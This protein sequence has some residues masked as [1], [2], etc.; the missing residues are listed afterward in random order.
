VRGLV[1]PVLGTDAFA[2]RGIFFDKIEGA[3]WKVPP[4][5][6]V[7][8]AVRERHDVDGFRAWS[9]KEGLMHVQPPA[10]VLERMATVRLHLDACG[11]DNGPLRVVA[12][13]HTQG[14]IS[15]DQV[16]RLA[17][18]GERVC[19]V[20]RGGAVIMRPLL[21]HSSSPSE[22]P[23]HRRVIHLEFACCE[24][25]APLEWHRKVR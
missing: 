7:T 10:T 8:I 3:N 1:D 22:N 13:S 6:D 14:K 5:Q 24:L 9:V 11:A 18:G 21:V 12:G 20:G 2:V 17:Q 19:A 4:H 16:D 25:P 23:S 15:A